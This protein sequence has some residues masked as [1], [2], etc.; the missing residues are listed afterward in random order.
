MY[1]H[2]QL[3]LLSVS[4][5]QANNGYCLL[6]I[7]DSKEQPF[8]E[9]AVDLIGPWVVQVRGKAHEFNALTAKEHSN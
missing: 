3:C 1:V 2:R 6:P 8:E 9:V 7:Q 4:E 5:P